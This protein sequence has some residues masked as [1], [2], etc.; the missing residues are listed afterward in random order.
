MSSGLKERAYAA[1][2]EVGVLMNNAGTG[3]G[4]GPFDHYDRWQHVIGVN[5]WGVINGV[6]AFAPAMIAQGTAGGD[7]QHRLEAGDHLPARRH[8]LQRVEGRREGR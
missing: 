5:L 8:R 7:R 4:G 6:H 2:G 1:F 3:P